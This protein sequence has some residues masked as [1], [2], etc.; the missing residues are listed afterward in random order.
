MD[1]GH[2]TGG[3]AGFGTSTASSKYG[4]D[5]GGGNWKCK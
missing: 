1:L 2:Y 5:F 3:G 4:F